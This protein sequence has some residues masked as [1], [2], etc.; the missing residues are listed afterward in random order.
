M[1]AYDVFQCDKKPS[2][3]AMYKDWAHETIKA[4]TAQK[5]RKAY[6][7]K[8]PEAALIAAQY[9]YMVNY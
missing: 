1:K 2:D 4:E 3:Y 6:I 9:L 8:H 7:V 5:A